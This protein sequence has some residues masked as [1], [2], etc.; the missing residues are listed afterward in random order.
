MLSDTWIRAGFVKKENNIMVSTLIYLKLWVDYAGNPVGVAI[1]FEYA[2]DIHYE[3]EYSDW[4]NYLQKQFGLTNQA[5]FRKSLCDYFENH[6]WLEFENSL[7][8]FGIKYDK[9]VF[10]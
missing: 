7:K 8:T 2:D 1:D 10:W 9:I 6:D 5:E 3:F 4:H